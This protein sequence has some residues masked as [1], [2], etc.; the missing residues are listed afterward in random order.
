MAKVMGYPYSQLVATVTP[1]ERV[2]CLLRRRF[3]HRDGNLGFCI[4]LGHPAVSLE[5]SMVADSVHLVVG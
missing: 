2:E 5:K 4:V 3:P 1:Y